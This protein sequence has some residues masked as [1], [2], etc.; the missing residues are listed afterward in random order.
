MCFLG[1]VLEELRTKMHP[2]PFHI[3]WVDAVCHSEFAMSFEVSQ[4]RV[5][6]VQGLGLRVPRRK[7]APSLQGSQLK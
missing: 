3:S 6:R 1:Q 2:S 7:N 5:R 4:D